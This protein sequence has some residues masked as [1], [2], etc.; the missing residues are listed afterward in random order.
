MLKS[1]YR[2]AFRH[3][4]A[5]EMANPADAWREL[6]EPDLPDYLGQFVLEDVAQQHVARFAGRYGLPMISGMGRW[7]SR[8]QDVEIDPVAELHDGSY[9]FGEVKWTSSPVRLGELFELERKVAAMLHPA[10]KKNPRYA[11]FS[12]GR[13]EEKL[14]LAAKEQGVPLVGAEELYA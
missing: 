12:A 3:R 6:V 13:F 7:W 2:Y 5:L 10:W 4:S 1:W 11:L 9:L 14:V 8:R